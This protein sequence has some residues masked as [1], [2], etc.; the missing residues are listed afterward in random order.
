MELGLVPCRLGYFTLF[1]LGLPLPRWD[2]PSMDDYFHFLEKET[3]VQED[4]T[5]KSKVAQANWSWN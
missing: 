1:D 3:P 2:R 4:S 5:T